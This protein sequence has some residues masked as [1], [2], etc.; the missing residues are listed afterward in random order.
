MRTEPPK[1]TFSGW[2][3]PKEPIR[4]EVPEG[5]LQAGRAAYSGYVTAE[6]GA[7]RILEAALR[8]QSENPVVPTDSQ[9]YEL[10]GIGIS[11][12]KRSIS[13]T[14]IVTT[15]GIVEEW[16]RR[17]YLAPEPEVP[18]EVKDL[19]YKGGEM[20]VDKRIIEAYRRGRGS[21]IQVEPRA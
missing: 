20:E 8:W 11:T 7:R 19:M 14:G 6:E 18:E 10:S 9:A 12:D 13:R 5:M 17:M 16:Q 15:Q 4:V 21:V 3:E 2:R 1:M